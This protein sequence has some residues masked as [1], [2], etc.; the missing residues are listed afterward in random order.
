MEKYYVLKQLRGIIADIYDENGEFR[1]DV[2]H[3]Y[4]S[5]AV[6]DEAIV[7]LKEVLSVVLNHTYFSKVTRV[8]VKDRTITRKELANSLNM[9]M[10]TVN[11]QL[12][13]D[14]KKFFNDFGEDCLVNLSQIKSTD[15]SV[16]RRKLF[17]LKGT[18]ESFYK[19]ID[20]DLTKA[21]GAFNVSLDSDRFK[22]IC[23]LLNIYTESYK[24]RVVDMLSTNDLGYINYLF[25]KVDKTEEEKEQFDILLAMTGK[26][27]LLTEEH[28]N[29]YKDL[30]YEDAELDNLK[31]G[32]K[33]GHS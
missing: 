26:L 18:E 5:N 14:I 21:Y 22:F 25:S 3:R 10:N 2:T 19:S 29:I 17:V 32:D 9:N 16:Y 28:V 23:T 15:L 6:S 33:N 20:L 31:G 13:R 4:I 1:K 12:Y 11:S 30:G 7:L 8:Y 27:D 24:S